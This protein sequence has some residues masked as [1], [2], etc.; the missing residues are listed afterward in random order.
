[1]EP[2]TG[3]QEGFRE[4]TLRYFTIIPLWRW[5]ESN[6]LWAKFRQYG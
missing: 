1:M 3:F 2:L 6:P 5:R 4:H